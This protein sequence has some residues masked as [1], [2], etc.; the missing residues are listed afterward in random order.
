MIPCM[1]KSDSHAFLTLAEAAEEIGC[2]RRFLE[3]RIEDG[4]LKVF[5][6]S[7]RL[8][9]VRRV[10]LERWIERHSFGGNDRTP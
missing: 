3:T 4:E 9:R 6:P 5:K 10:E 2:T 7:S 8:V 1:P